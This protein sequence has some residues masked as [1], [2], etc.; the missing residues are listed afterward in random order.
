MFD[1]FLS[2]NSTLAA[3]DDIAI[4]SVMPDHDHL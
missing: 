3:E 4:K 2:S 1:F